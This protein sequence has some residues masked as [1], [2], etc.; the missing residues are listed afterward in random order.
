MTTLKHIRIFRA[1]CCLHIHV[2]A[3][4]VVFVW[5]DSI[6]LI[7]FNLWHY[8]FYFIFI[9]LSVTP[10]WRKWAS[11]N[12]NLHKK[13]VEDGDGPASQGDIC[14]CVEGTQCP[15]GPYSPFPSQIYPVDVQSGSKAGTRC[16]FYLFVC[17]LFVFIFNRPLG[18]AQCAHVGLARSLP[19][20]N[21][22]PLRARGFGGG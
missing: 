17:F 18:R 4:A 15:P 11:S 9:I 7:P 6:H 2:P 1:V 16:L 13:E 10:R 14:S 5:D 19:S 8:F 12:R 20:T 22:C 3:P 21:P